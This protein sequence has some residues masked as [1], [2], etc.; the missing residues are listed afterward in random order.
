[1]NTDHTLEEVGKQFSVARERVRQIEAKGCET[2]AS[3]KVA[4]GRRE[5]EAAL[6][7]QLLP[8]KTGRGGEEDQKAASTQGCE[9]G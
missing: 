8:R 3:V 9:N 5:R 1:M 4:R 7:F 6:K 2:E